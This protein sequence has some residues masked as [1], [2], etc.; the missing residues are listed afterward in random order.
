MEIEATFPKEEMDL[1]NA[2]YPNGLPEEILEKA[3]VNLVEELQNSIDGAEVYVHRI[4][5]R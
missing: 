3:R 4:E 5:M 1:L 2:I